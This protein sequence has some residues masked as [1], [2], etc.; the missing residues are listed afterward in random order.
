MPNLK[1]IM[2]EEVEYKGV[3]VEYANEKNVIFI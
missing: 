1:L 3:D 2:S